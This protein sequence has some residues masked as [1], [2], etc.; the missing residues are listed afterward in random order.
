M[1]LGGTGIDFHRLFEM[2]D[3]I[4]DLALLQEDSSQVPVRRLILGINLLRPF[5]VGDGVRP[6]TGFIIHT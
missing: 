5:E 6:V 1:G 4:A 2:N 3:G